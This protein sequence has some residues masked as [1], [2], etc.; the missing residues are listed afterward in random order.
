M[1]AK[2]FFLFFIALVSNFL[3][4]D[5]FSNTLNHN[6]PGVKDFRSYRF[7][8]FKN[9]D[10]KTWKEML[11]L[12][13]GRYVNNQHIHKE[14][15]AYAKEVLAKNNSNVI[16][17][18]F[19]VKNSDCC[20]KNFLL[21]DA[22]AVSECPRYVDIF[23]PKHYIH[24]PDYDCQETIILPKLVL[25]DRIIPSIVMTPPKLELKDKLFL[26]KAFFQ[27]AK[28]CVTR[29]LF[30]VLNDCCKKPTGNVPDLLYFSLLFPITLMFRSFLKLNF[31]EDFL[32]TKMGKFVLNGTAFALGGM[33]AEKFSSLYPSISTWFMKKYFNKKKMLQADAFAARLCGADVAKRCIGYEE[34]RSSH[35]FGLD[36][37]EIL[38]S[39]NLPNST[40]ECSGMVLMV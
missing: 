12:L 11:N 26:E 19:V 1:L 16:P 25:K 40:G 4:A 29:E 2:K 23:I 35:Y 3:R 36:R 7:E 17:R 32:V 24:G 22:C 31:K 6:A 18:V 14:L 28:A 39:L 13:T 38:D 27:R 34:S 9:D 10:L 20:Y 37:L 30:F 33:E 8:T 5:D 21:V 15:T